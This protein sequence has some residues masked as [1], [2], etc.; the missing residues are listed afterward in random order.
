M[1]KEISKVYDPKIV[2][3]RLYKEW[4][5]KGYFKGIVDK[6]KKPFSIVMP[7]PNITGQLHMG[8]ALDNLMQDALTRFKRMQGFATL[9]QPGTDHA[10]I[11]T[12]VKIVEMLAKEGETKE[13]IGRERFL[14][15]AWEWRELY[16]GRIVTQ[17]KEL[18][19]SCDWE[20]ERFTMDEGCSAAVIE[21]FIRLHEK[22]L[23]YQGDRIINWCPDCETALSDAEVEHEDKD[24]HL[25][26]MR[27]PAS[28]GGIGIVVATTRPETMLGDTAVAVNPKDDRYKDLIG[29]TVRLPLM[30]KDIPVVADDYVDMEFGTGAVKITPAHDPN[31]FEMGMRHGMEV[32]RVLTDDG[33]IN[34]KGGKYKGQDRYE[35][36]KNIIKDIEAL[37]LM[38]KIE[39]YS[40]SVGQCYRCSTTVEP[41][42]SK[43]WFISMKELAKPAIDAV[44]EGKIKFVPERFDK[45]YFNWMENIRDWCISRQLWWGHRIPA[46][47]C[48]CGETMVAREM[49]EKCTRCGGTNLRQD[50]DVLDTWFSS[51]LWPFSTLGWP[52]KT[53]ELE[54]FYPTN[55]LVTGYDI[56]FFW[57]ARMI[58]FG[59]EVMGEIPYEFVSIHG[60]VRD[61]QGRKMSKSLNNGIDPLEIIDKYGA[62]ALRFSLAQGNSPGGDMRFYLEKVE[63][64]RN[65]ANKIWNA[66]RFVMMNLNEAEADTELKNLDISDKWILTLLNELI[67]KVTDNL[68]KF[69]FGLA[70]S[71][72]YDFLWSEFCDWYIEMAKSRLYGEN[73]ADKVTANGVL[74]KVLRD[75][76][77]LLHP[78]MPF[79]TEEIYTALAG[80]EKTIMTSEWPT[81][82]KNIFENEKRSMEMVMDLIR[83]IRN[84]R[85]EMNVVPSKKAKLILLTDEK[86]K[87][88]LKECEAYLEKL[89]FASD[90][91]FIKDKSGVP[92]DAVS[93]VSDIAECF[94]PLE[95]LMDISKEIE[96]LEKEM[97]ELE[98]EIKRANGKLNNKGFTDKAPE[99]VVKDEKAKLE[100]YREFYKKVSERLISLKER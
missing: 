39:D 8:H 9:W 68:E 14:E 88:Q 82:D 44:K 2:E 52:E 100:K 48:G 12:E 73:I 99:K 65:F 60:I 45:T 36:R 47:Y 84:I 55:V 46:Y 33:N 96:R 40:H 51:G 35:A 19:S 77:K 54:F 27:Y 28:D 30:D 86:K 71:N 10:S 98:A 78:L 25:W 49:P 69:E 76:L 67:E 89:A 42:V 16:G 7:P 18:G 75:T 53:E 22:G 3:K 32:I 74:L 34:E 62:D 63:A 41:I 64:C 23:V 4:M 87:A 43:Q 13:S 56:I 50:E 70:A 37:G 21:V 83:Q 1:S 91:E 92:N 5:D 24:S 90:I 26:Y 79:I 15:K 38:V 11:A 29:K 6:S 72:T 61:A 94:M 57:V 20:R 81:V 58:F 97:A 31:D 17:L 80:N 59:I 95:D 66:S 93:V 85:A